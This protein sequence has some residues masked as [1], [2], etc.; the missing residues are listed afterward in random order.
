MH[1]DRDPSCLPNILHK[2]EGAISTAERESSGVETR[3]G[4]LPIRTEEQN[5][6]TSCADKCTLSGQKRTTRTSEWNRDGCG[7]Q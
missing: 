7:E 4:V 3:E 6:Q 1:P 5:F 2:L